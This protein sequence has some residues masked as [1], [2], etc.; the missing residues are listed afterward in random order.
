MHQR[1][2]AL[3]HTARDVDESVPGHLHKRAVHAGEARICLHEGAHRSDQKRHADGLHGNVTQ[4]ARRMLDL[5]VFPEVDDAADPEFA[6]SRA[7]SVVE[8]REV[9]GPEEH[10]GTGL[11]STSDRQSADVAEVGGA[12]DAEI[13]GRDHAS[14]CGGT[15]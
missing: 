8:C 14:P 15:A 6:Q 11:P 3:E 13:L 9:A 7:A 2:C 12:G 4:Q 1:G 5:L 10:A